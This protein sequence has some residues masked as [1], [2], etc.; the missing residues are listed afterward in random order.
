[1]VR[2]WSEDNGERQRHMRYPASEKLETIE[3]VK[4][5][6]LPA[7]RT[8]DMLG[9]PWATLYRWYDLWRTGGPEALADKPSKPDLVWNKIR[10]TIQAQIV[11]L[12]L[13]AAELS[14][15]EIAAHSDHFG[16]LFRH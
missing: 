13:E 10:D 1:M 2:H 5:S 4:Q 16:R 15:R 6:H 7:K 9:I 14:P 12:A 3:I 8:L 11:E